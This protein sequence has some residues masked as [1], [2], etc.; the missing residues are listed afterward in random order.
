M[1]VRP[2]LGKTAFIVHGFTDSYIQWKN[3]P[4]GILFVPHNRKNRYEQ[5]LL[6][7]EYGTVT[8]ISVSCN[9]ALV[10]MVMLANKM[11]LKKSSKSDY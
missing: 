1:K 10:G 8:Y 5:Y 6:F 9:T 4:M 2:V 3:R 7:G 11:F